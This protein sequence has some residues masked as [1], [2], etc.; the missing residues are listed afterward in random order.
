MLSEGAGIDVV[1]RGRSECKRDRAG[2]RG[3]H[4]LDRG[5][6]VKLLVFLEVSELTVIWCES[7]SDV[8]NSYTPFSKS[9]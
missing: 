2:A 7:C 6:L 3:I 8:L 9:K 4:D 1:V 5:Q